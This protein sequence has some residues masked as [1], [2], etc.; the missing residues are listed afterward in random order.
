MKIL[1]QTLKQSQKPV[2]HQLALI[3]RDKRFPEAQL[4]TSWLQPKDTILTKG[5]NWL[6][7]CVKWFFPPEKQKEPVSS[8]GVKVQK[9]LKEKNTL[10]NKEKTHHTLHLF[11]KK[12][13][14]N[15]L[16]H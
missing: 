3:V 9:T 6:V 16:V 11:K 7:R 4:T 8:T 12:N 1:Q 10:L 15:K 5:N 14:F 13:P 2:L